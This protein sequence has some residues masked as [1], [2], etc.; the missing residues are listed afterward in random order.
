[1]SS[2]I[3]DKVYL[4]VIGAQLLGT[5][6]LDT[7]TI[8][9]PSLWRYPSSPLH[10]LLSLRAWWATYSGDPYFTSLTHDAWFNG[11]LYVEAFVQLPLMV[12]LVVK[13]SASASASAPNSTSGPTELAGLVYGCVTF[14]GTLACCFDIWHMGPERVRDE[15]WGTAI[16]AI[17][18]SL[19]LLP[20]LQSTPR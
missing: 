13:L 18:M 6:L 7:L 20:R 3:R 9:P 1:M 5:L 19:R 4:P 10:G 11:F 15:Q 17:D 8:L 14:M 12:Y 16:M 2:R